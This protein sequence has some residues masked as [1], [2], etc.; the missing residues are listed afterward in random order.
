MVDENSV[1]DTNINK[2]VEAS[3]E[4][5][6]KAAN[7]GEPVEVL[8][9]HSSVKTNIGGLLKGS[10]LND[11]PEKLVIS[12]NTAN[13][14]EEKAV[15]QA[16]DNR[17]TVEPVCEVNCRSNDTQIADGDGRVVFEENQNVV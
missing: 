7:V 12:D 11:G 4:C 6:S 2:L 13:N 10:K 15:N 1:V 3:K 17:V 9:E 5:S 8:N 14:D 16:Y